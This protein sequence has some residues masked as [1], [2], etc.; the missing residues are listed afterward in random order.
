MGLFVIEGSGDEIDKH[1]I[2]MLESIDK[3]HARVPCPSSIPIF[4]L[5]FKVALILEVY[6]HDSFTSRMVYT[7]L[8]S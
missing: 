6:G 2:R 4:N 7:V 8:Y 3:F 1:L 5:A